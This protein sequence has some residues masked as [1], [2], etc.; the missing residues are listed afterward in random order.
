MGT[1]NSRE[2]H[3]AQLFHMLLVAPREK[4]GATYKVEGR[5]PGKESHLCP[6]LASGVKNASPKPRPGS[7]WINWLEL[8]ATLQGEPSSRGHTEA[9]LAHTLLPSSASWSHA[10]N[11]HT[12]ISP[13][14]W[15]GKLEKTKV[16]AG[17][18]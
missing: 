10:A 16:S 15:A 14:L 3:I 2:G 13:L 18:A 4:A 8:Q 1:N 6:A 12:A 17:G 7:V 9:N 5:V 11:G